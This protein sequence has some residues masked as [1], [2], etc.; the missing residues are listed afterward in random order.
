MLLLGMMPTVA[1]AATTN[2]AQDMTTVTVATGDTF[3]KMSKMYSVPLPAIEQANA[4]LNPMN[5]QV[6]QTV[7]IPR[8]WT[9]QRGDTLYRIAHTFGVSVQSIAELNN[10]TNVDQ[11]G[12]GTFLLIPAQTAGN[13]TSV[14]LTWVVR[15]GDNLMKIS[16]T[17]GASV[18]Q[19]SALNGLQNGNPSIGLSLLIPPT[20]KQWTQPSDQP[21]YN[22]SVIGGQ[23]YNLEAVSD[24]TTTV[25]FHVT[26]QSYQAVSGQTVTLTSDNPSVVT[27]LPYATGQN[28]QGTDSNGNWNAVLQSHGVVGTARLS[29]SVDGQVINYYSVKVED[30]VA[31]IE[32]SMP[33]T[34]ITANSTQNYEV[35]A[36][37]KDSSGNPLPNLVLNVVGS[38]WAN[39]TQVV[40]DSQGKATFTIE[41]GNQSGNLGV[42]VQDPISN[43][44]GYVNYTVTDGN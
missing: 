12:I 44:S 19:I 4:S 29:L 6:G 33:V 40:T 26:D 30:P 16:Q 36:T 13:T 31:K 10:I 32:L 9:V 34:T 17:T 28:G 35:D 18:A 37:V 15:P 23:L 3:W 27:V 25:G 42:G 38:P 7:H 2:V 22:V 43:V 24:A 11:L 5:L 8:T 1:H 14:F 21:T 41:A 39:D 20:N